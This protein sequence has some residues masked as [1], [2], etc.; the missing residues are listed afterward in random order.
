M[1]TR[2]GGRM[3]RKNPG[4]LREGAL[5]DFVMLDMNGIHHQPCLAQCAA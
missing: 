4:L 2:N 3:L 5:A 1:A